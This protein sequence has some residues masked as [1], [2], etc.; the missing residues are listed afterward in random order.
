MSIS[1]P[2]DSPPA[3]TAREGIEACVDDCLERTLNA[4]QDSGVASNEEIMRVR[5]RFKGTPEEE[6]EAP[7]D[8]VEL[9][10]KIQG[11]EEERMGIEVARISHAVSEVITPA[12]PLIPFAGKLMAPSAFYEAYTQLHE[13]SKA[14]LSPVIFAED[15]D[16]IGTG[17]LNPVAAQIMGEEI[18]SAVSRRF[19]IRPFVT[20]IRLDY[21]SWCFLS[22]KHFGL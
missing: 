9:L 16:A 11:T 21:E 17:A 22:R 5:L 1:I 7:K 18:L 19:G 13:T 20:T 14:L 8:L 12:V 2:L 3:T 4:F 15:T 10:A 6:T